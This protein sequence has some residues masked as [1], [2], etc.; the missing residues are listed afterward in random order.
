M[1]SGT[2]PLP[3]DESSGGDVKPEGGRADSASGMRRYVPHF[4]VLFVVVGAV[5]YGAGFASSRFGVSAAG[6]MSTFG[7]AVLLVEK[8]A[9]TRK[10]RAGAW[11]TLVA[12][13]YAISV[14]L[15]PGAE[16]RSSS[17]R[18][19]RDWCSRS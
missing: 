2:C 18:S 14:A 15:R 5:G 1:R 4:L 12:G 13:S 19:S 10:A 17:P 3:G 8:R 9:H 6:V 11:S 16:R 7:A